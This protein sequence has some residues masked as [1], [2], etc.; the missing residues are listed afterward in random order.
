MEPDQENDRRSSSNSKIHYLHSADKKSSKSTKNLSI[1]SKSS[2]QEEASGS[3]LVAV[4]D[5]I[6]NSLPST[7]VYCLRPAII[8]KAV[9]FFVE[10]FESSKNSTEILYSVKSNPDRQV[11]VHLF[12]SGI[13]HFDVAS[14]VE[15]K[16]INELFG[17]KVKMYFM[18][19]IKSRES[20]KEAYFDFG[21]RD[22]SLDSFDELHKILD[23]TNSAKDLGLHVRLSIPNSHSAIDLS[24]K[25]GILPSESV[26]LLRKVR[27]SATRLGICFHVGS[28]CMDP[29]EYRN[30]IM[31]T[32]EVVEN[33][34]VNLDVL[35]VGGGFPSIYPGMTPPNL[36]SYFDEIFDSI[37]QLNLNSKCKIWCEP[38]RALVAEAGS[39][40]VRVEG[41]KN[42]ML[43]INDGT[44]GGLFDAGYPGFIYHTK[45]I[46]VAKKSALSSQKDAFGFYGPT[47]DSLDTMKGPFYLPENIGEGDYIEIGQLGAYSRSIRTEFNGF[48]KNIQIEVKDEPL[49][50]MYLNLSP[51]EL[52]NKFKF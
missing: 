52:S 16:L 8:K 10:N 5:F 2:K 29:V 32:K 3:G 24:G 7:P 18:H 34:K 47:C 26:G 46:R 50:S 12:E 38:G 20:I 37:N 30:A 33:A 9:D 31:I 42:N 28:Q 22:F 48:N 51:Q 11:L 41:R 27:A 21:I 43:Y 23:S 19:P 13:K 44:Y 39:L 35:D 36:Q 49:E 15:V 4:N 17:D 45:A 14:I 6:K 25:F 1:K 40:V